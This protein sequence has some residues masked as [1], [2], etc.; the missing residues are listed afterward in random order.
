MPR[1]CKFLADMTANP[2]G[3]DRPGRGRTVLIAHVSANTDRDL[4]GN[5]GSGEAKRHELQG[6]FENCLHTGKPDD[7]S[8]QE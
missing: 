6:A 8:R 3:F 2:A 1:L 5:Q 4:S 7:F